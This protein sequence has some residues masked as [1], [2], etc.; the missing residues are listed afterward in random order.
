M[1]YVKVLGCRIAATDIEEAAEAICKKINQ[2][3]GQYII[4]ANTHVVVMASE[5]EAYA[6]AQKESLITFADGFPVAYVQQKKGM[7]QA[8]RVAGPD[9][10]TEIFKKSTTKGYRH[11]FYGSNEE[12][13]TCLKENLEHKYPGIQIVGTYSPV[14]S[15]ELAKDY[16]QDIALINATNPD[17]VWIGLGAP[18]QELWMHRHKDKVHGLMLGVGAG[19]DFHADTKKRAPLWMQRCGLE[20]LYRLLQEPDRLLKRYLVTNVKFVWKVIAQR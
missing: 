12:T 1:K 10:M 20:W 6:Q 13:L 2:C 8:K 4:F 17:F 11:F 16:S 19:F 3:K 9:F 15:K 18:K 5:D 14:Y 7:K